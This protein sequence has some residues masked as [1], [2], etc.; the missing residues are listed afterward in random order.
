MG[1]VIGRGKEDSYSH[2]ARLIRVDTINTELGKG[3]KK[4]RRCCAVWSNPRIYTN[5]RRFEKR[6]DL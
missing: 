2:S 4:R 6:R 3:I 5:C 1:I